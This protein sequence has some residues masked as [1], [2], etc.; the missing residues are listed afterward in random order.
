MSAPDDAIPSLTE[1]MPDADDRLGAKLDALLDALA[2]ARPY[3]RSAY[4]TDVFH[5]AEALLQTEDGLALLAAR[6]PRYDSAGVFL[7][8]P[9]EDASKLRPPLVA[10]SLQAAGV[11]AIV[12]ILSEL[13]MLAIATGRATSEH[14]TQEEASTFLEEVM[15]LNLDYL[16]PRETE[17]E[18]V[19]SGEPYRAVAIR[20][21]ALLAQE[22]GLASLRDEVVR[23]VDQLAAQRPV[24][25]TRIRRMIAMA[26][27][28]PTDAA[29][30]DVADD[31][32]RDRLAE[33]TEAVS[34]PTPLSR[35]HPDL[36][37][38]RLAIKDADDIALQAE[39]DGFVHSTRRT[40]L[41]APPH[42]ILVRRMITRRPEIVAD[43]LDL[44]DAGR[45]ELTAA[46]DLAQRMIKVA[47]V[48]GTAQSLIGLR[49]VFERGLLSQPAVAAGLERLVSLDLTPELRRQLLSTRGK[50]DGVTAN[51]ML[52]AGAIAVLGQPL[53]V[54]QGRN[55][56][57]QAARGISLWAQHAP[58]HLLELLI[59]AA[60]DG[61]VE[62]WFEGDLLKSNELM[63]Q[64]P[65]E[66]DL[67]LDPV[68]IALVPHLDQLYGEMMRRVSFRGE[69]AHKWVNPGL[70][71]RWVPTG[72]A[73]VFHDVGQTTVAAYEDF[74]RRFYATHHP[75]STTGI[76]SRIR[77][78]SVSASRTVTA[79]TSDR[80]PC[81]CSAS[82]SILRASCAR[83]SSI[84]TAKGVRT[85]DTAFG[86][87]SPGTV[88]RRGSH[89][90]RWRRSSRGSTH[91][92]SI[93]TKRA[94]PTPCRTSGFA[95]LN[96]TPAGRGAARSRGRSSRIRTVGVTGS[97]LRVFAGGQFECGADGED[98]EH[99]VEE[100]ECGPKPV[101]RDLARE[102]AQHDELAADDREHRH[103]HC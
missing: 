72:F 83:T 5:Y 50:Q 2:S 20:L 19:R 80:T 66:F 68:S 36:A 75:S 87:R 17:E 74:V 1:P 98:E 27:R 82:R 62:M 81:R 15:A 95:R 13:R 92:T 91:S 32:T 100:A 94:T 14:V 40:G 42:A 43:A 25:T 69:D 48:P 10:G 4:Q 77:T 90:C 38:Y 59:A 29:A 71:G 86:P 97:R 39:V 73:S 37:A 34:G 44:N 6:A 88:R 30:V 84:R 85:G 22:F 18:R 53:G 3:A 26:A 65:R 103:Q 93:R 58:A 70:Y 101:K 31:P 52:L 23:E 46:D 21:F 47:I 45:A 89:R 61:T 67:D 102:H 78:R 57:C 63:H 51:A 24:V 12:E 79:T 64:A 60:R 33:F 76:R 96:R 9:W 99:D 8:G 41:V 55:P 54:G 7:G 49:R 56:T 28:I 16:F 35:A 11:Y